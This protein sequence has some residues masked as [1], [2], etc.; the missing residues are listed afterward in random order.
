M[1]TVVSSKNTKTEILEAYE[2]LLEEVQKA[3]ANH[4]KLQQE[5]KQNKEISDRV[6]DLSKDNIGKSIENLKVTLNG[7]LNELLEGLSIEYKKLSDIKTAIAVEEK[8]LEDLYSLTAN[9]DSLATMLLVQKEKKEAFE[10]EMTEARLLWETEKLKHKTAEEE[11]VNEVAKRR[12]RE[13]EEYTY[14]LKTARQKDTDEYKSKVQQLE[15]ELQERKAQ[16]EQEMMERETNL[17]TAEAEL[18]ELRK[19]HAEYPQMLEKAL[20][21]KETEITKSLKTEYEFKN[22]LSEQQNEAEIRLKDQ[23]ITS[24]QEKIKELQAQVK[25]YADKALRAETSV[26]DIALKA[27]QN[28]SIPRYVKEKEGE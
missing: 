23:Q 6:S 20:T 11:Y 8:K 7:S 16:F 17:K 24:L 28:S 22:R 4:P 1:A 12:K 5:E 15:R 19:Y 3:K 14:H 18:V 26:K 27:I 9:T 10:K 25:E 2:N 21:D 13:E